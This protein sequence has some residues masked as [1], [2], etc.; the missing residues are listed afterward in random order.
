MVEFIDKHKG[1]RIWVCGSGPSL[2]KV[3][4]DRLTD[5]DVVIACNSA[6]LHFERPDYWLVIDASVM[7][8]PYFDIHPKQQVINLNPLIRFKKGVVHYCYY[9]SANH[10]DWR[11]RK[12]L[13]FPGH[14]TQRAVSFAYTMGA[15][16][17]ILAGCDCEGTHPYHPEDDAGNQFDDDLY[18]WRRVA[19]HNLPIVTLSTNGKT[20]F[21]I[22]TFDQAIA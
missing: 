19:E 5:D 12:H 7:R 16:K 13:H 22:V 9:S 10:D 11:L 3:Q 14:S 15:A 4:Q 21:P 6:R 2:L 20:P 17:I 1:K 18:Y 8:R